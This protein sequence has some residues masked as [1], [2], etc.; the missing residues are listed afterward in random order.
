MELSRPRQ[1]A[2][3][4]AAVTGH[5]EHGSGVQIQKFGHLSGIQDR[6]VLLANGFET[7]G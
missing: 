4:K 3:W 6:R 7:V 5:V 1:P 2:G